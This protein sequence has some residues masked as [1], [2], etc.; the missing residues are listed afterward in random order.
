MEVERRILKEIKEQ[1]KKYYSSD[2][3]LMT[4]DYART[5]VDLLHKVEDYLEEIL[6]W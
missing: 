6:L 3:T 2:N 5:S 1:I 4:L